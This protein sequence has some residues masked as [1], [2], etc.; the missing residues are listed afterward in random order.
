MLVLVQY[1]GSSEGSVGG[2]VMGRLANKEIT[3]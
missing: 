3:G 1:F 2:V